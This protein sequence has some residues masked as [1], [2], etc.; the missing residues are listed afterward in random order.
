VVAV[1]VAV[2]LSTAPAEDAV[3]LADASA[4]VAAFDIAGAAELLSRSAGADV[5][6]QVAAVYLRGLVDAREAS[7][8]G[9]SAETLA[10]VRAA[11]TWLGQVANGRPG[12]AEIAR[13]LLHAAAAAAQS[14]R[15]EMRLYLDTA[16]RMETAQRAAGLPGAPVIS[17]AEAAGDLWLLVHG[18]ADARQA[19]AEA[20]ARPSP[21]LRLLA[22]R[23]RAD[24]GLGDTT[25][26]CEAYRQL[27]ER[28]AARPAEPAE[29]A[30]A[31]MFV[32]NSCVLPGR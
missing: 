11:I 20:A 7:R 28:W 29:I 8:Q 4:R 5:A 18:Y 32:V 30:D 23:A 1:F 13:L 12:P 10:P 3:V 21:S 6:V 31:R 14:E 24:R 27:L 22:N 26:A 17:A 19:Y 9:G 16:M 2:S 25:A 15:D